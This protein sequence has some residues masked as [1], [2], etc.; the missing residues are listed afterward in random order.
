[1]KSSREIE[2][3]VALYGDTVYRCAYTYCGNRHDA[4]DI[5][6]EVFYRFMTKAPV[7]AEESYEKAWLLRVTINLSKNYVRSFW[8]RNVDE[9]K[10]DVP[11]LSSEETYI[12]EK[13]RGLPLKYRTVLSLYYVEGYSIREIAEILGKKSSTVGTWL[14]RGK[15]L[16]RKEMEE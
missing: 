1:M 3:A 2:K 16:L 11:G 9:L 5:M 8:Y 15:A 14:E 12:W 13:V 6:Q 4:E 7:F 10:E